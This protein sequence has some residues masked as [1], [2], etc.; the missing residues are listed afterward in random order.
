MNLRSIRWQL[1]LGY[2]ALF[3]ATNA[4]LLTAFYYYEKGAR[5]SRL[6]QQMSAI[7]MELFPLHFSNPALPPP[8]IAGIDKEY[9]KQIERRGYYI[10]TY[11]HLGRSAYRS[12]HAPASVERPVNE[13]EGQPSGR[14]NG[15]AR[16][17]VKI[18]PHDD[19]LVLG[20]PLDTFHADLRRLALW[21]WLAGAAIVAAG[22]VGG[23]WISS[24]ALRPIREISDTARQIAEGNWEK[25]ID[26]SAAPAELSDLRDLL[27]ACFSRIAAAYNQQAR[28]TADAAH[29]LGTP[30][31]IVVSQSEMVLAR[32]RSPLEYINALEACLRAGRRMKLLL[33]DLLELA[34][35]EAGASALEFSKCDL[36]HIVED[37]LD[38]VETLKNE[39]SAEIQVISQSIMIRANQIALGQALVNL[40]RNAMI[41]NDPGVRVT[42]KVTVEDGRHVHIEVSDNGR[43]IPEQTLPHIFDRF[44]RVDKSRTRSNGGLGLGL[45][46]VKAIVE[47]HN[48]SICADN[49]PGGGMIF[50]ISLASIS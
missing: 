32:Q 21:L 9:E 24:R 15:S 27:N 2:A 41:H 47:V 18:S 39:R 28:F 33:R 34:D 42:L 6:D 40:L 37:A 45:S 29:E 20:M 12:A 49:S 36:N 19:S 8:I 31:A 14:W 1:Q 16:E 48:G 25:R 50:R 13:F 38:L 44:F 3:A 11:D 35:Y 30:V 17:M 46:I 4:I 22:L 26:A 23:Y 7:V 43:G 10:V 5:F